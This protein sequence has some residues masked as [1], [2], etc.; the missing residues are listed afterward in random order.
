MGIKDVAT[1]NANKLLKNA[2]VN[3]EVKQQQEI[4]TSWRA[5]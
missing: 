4:K 2:K 3:E 5:Y 1:V